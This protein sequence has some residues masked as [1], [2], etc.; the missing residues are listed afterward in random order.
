MQEK[1]EQYEAEKKKWQ[2]DIIKLEEETKAKQRQHQEQVQSIEEQLAEAQTNMNEKTQ[3]IELL[4]KQVTELTAIPAPSTPRVNVTGKP[5]FMRILEE[6]NS[7]GK[8]RPPAAMPFADVRSQQANVGDF[9]RLQSMAGDSQPRLAQGNA[10]NF[11]ALQSMAGE[12]Q[13]RPAQGNAGNFKALQSMA[14]EGQPRPAQG[15][16]G[17]FKAL[18]S[19]AMDGQPRHVQGNRANYTAPN[20][21]HSSEGAGWSAQEIPNQHES[22]R[23]FSAGD[24]ILMDQLPLEYTNTS[25]AVKKNVNPIQR[26]K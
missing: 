7:I 12:G 24:N 1:A 5:W 4:E 8:T 21:F 17:N 2:E 16:A 26:E 10:G 22:G 20:D 11:K 13:P 23:V 9:R 14:G 6:Q 19:M 15:N 18:Q 25:H 3:T